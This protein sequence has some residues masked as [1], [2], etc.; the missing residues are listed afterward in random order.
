[1]TY[2]WR[3]NPEIIARLVETA[4]ISSFRSKDIVLEP[5]ESMTILQDGK[6]V[7]TY[8]EQRMS[9]I[10]GGIGK[11]LFFGRKP[12]EKFLF[13]INTPFKLQYE[14]D[15]RSLDAMEVKGAVT[16]EMQIQLTDAPRLVNLFAN[17]PQNPLEKGDSAYI[18]R[19]T[20]AAILTDEIGH[21][22]LQDEIG[23][24]NL[25]EIRSSEE[26]QLNIRDKL[27]TNMRRTHAEFGLT[28][29]QNQ[30]VFSPNAHDKV[31][32]MRGQLNLE[33]GVEEIEQDARIF[34]LEDKYQL[35]HREL[36]LEAESQL[37][38]AKGEDDVAIQHQLSEIKMQQLEFDA[39]L[40]QRIRVQTHELNMKREK[41][42]MDQEVADQ[43]LE[44]RFKSGDTTAQE[45]EFLLQQQQMRDELQSS[46]MDK[47]R[48]MKTEQLDRTQIDA[49][50]Q[51]ELMQQAMKAISSGKQGSS[52]IAGML[53]TLIEQQAITQR[54]NIEQETQQQKEL[55]KQQTAQQFFDRA[56]N[57]N[58]DMTF[59]QGDLIS[60][61]PAQN[62]PGPPVPPEKQSCKSC[63]GAARYISQYRRWYCDQCKT[64]N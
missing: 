3:T 44:R 38:I 34:A 24:H 17:I 63:S 19:T 26:L 12:E 10:V 21:K 6:I 7:D 15:C 14:F 48:S 54:T 18:T 4:S 56:G 41:M 58:G 42:L 40:E 51:A 46:Q 30:I 25:S 31:Q 49:T 27:L 32:Q 59:V 2:K 37:V 33:R 36:E 29:R 9:K 53:Q 55:L 62:N 20:L 64:Y 39:Q 43:E 11:K 1:M 50:N 60:G 61:N 35:I 45:R 22:V 57:A 5:T 23:Q 13:T 28:F 47:S 16:L 8:T 52:E